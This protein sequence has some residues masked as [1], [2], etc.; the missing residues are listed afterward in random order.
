MNIIY[1]PGKDNVIADALSRLE[2]QLPITVNEFKEI[3]FDPPELGTTILSIEPVSPTSYIG[4]EVEVP[5][6]WWGT[7]YARTYGIQRQRFR[8]KVVEYLP[9]DVPAKRRWKLLLPAGSTPDQD[10]D[11]YYEMSWTGLQTYLLPELLPEKPSQENASNDM[12]ADLNNNDDLCENL[13]PT[14]LPDTE[15]P[16]ENQLTVEEIIQH[17]LADKQLLPLINFLKD[18][19]RDAN[20]SNT[21]PTLSSKFGLHLCDYLLNEEGLLMHVE[22]GQTSTHSIFRQQI[23][24]PT[25]LQERVMYL[26]HGSPIAAHVGISRTYLTFVKNIIGLECVVILLAM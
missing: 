2:R 23:V 7:K 9:N 17:Q 18:E 24:I 16:M 12:S 19:Q 22:H 20:S 5:G 6:I 10:R 14:D 21:I 13:S 3:D 25:T 4:R 11:E 1:G 26:H 15:L 8:M